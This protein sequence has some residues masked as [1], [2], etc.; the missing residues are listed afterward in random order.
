MRKNESPPFASGL[1]F[2][3]EE[4][5]H[6]LLVGRE[7]YI[8]DQPVTCIECGWDGVGGELNTGHLPAQHIQAYVYAYRCAH[9]GSF[10]VRRKARVLAFRRPAKIDESEAPPKLN[11]NRV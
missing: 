3:V 9:C 1:S 11:R 6:M 2:R 5:K 4:R 7:L 8:Q 10:D